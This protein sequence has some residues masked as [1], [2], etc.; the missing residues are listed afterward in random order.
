[1]NWREAAWLILSLC[2][3]SHL[4]FPCQ[5]EIRDANLESARLFKEGKFAEADSVCVGVLAREPHSYGALLLRGRIVLFANKLDEAEKWLRKASKLKP[6]DKDLNTLLAEVFYRR[7]DFQRAAAFFRLAGKEP[8]ARQ[9]E[10]FKGQVP[11]QIEGQVSPARVKFIHTDPLPLVPAKVND[12][13]EVN[14]LVDTGGSE[15]IIDP[16]LAEKVGVKKF[17]QEDRTFGGGKQAPVEFGHI[18]SLTLGGLKLKNLPAHILSTQ[19]FSAAARGK[20][21]SGVLGTVLLY[22]FLATLD[23]PAGELILERRSKE[24]VRRLEQRA[25]MENQFV[26]P[27]WMAGDH[28]MVA[29]GRVSR[30]APV[31][32][33]ID[34][35]LAGGA[36]TG[37]RSII[38]S[39]GIKLK[40]D[41]AGEGVGGGGKTTVI[42][43]D[44][45]ALELGGAREQNLRG[46]FGPFPPSLEYSMGFRIGGIVSHQFFRPYALTFDFTGMRLFLRRKL[47]RDSA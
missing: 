19:A 37:P 32:L 12:G 20:K 27:F 17:G 23:Y 33:F 10:S 46:F 14:F 30:A 31:L 28:L 15:V 7:D 8:I 9:L 45:E 26:V 43:F 38:D 1:M 4:V 39:A 41:R 21:V 18:N 5:I 13:E 6:E 29:W 40:E 22:H 44:I 16:E 34:T 24:N 11:Y 36:Y 3:G 2:L 35:G 25:K 47:N 42:P